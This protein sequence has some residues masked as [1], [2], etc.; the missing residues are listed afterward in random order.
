MEIL[1]DGYGRSMGFSTLKSNDKEGGAPREDVL[2]LR[3]CRLAMCSEVNPK[4]KFDTALVKKLVSGETVVAR[5]IRA[6]DSA[7]YEPKYKIFI[8]TNYAPIIPFDDKGSYRRIR[9][10]PFKNVIAEDKKDKTLKRT[11]KNEREARE[12]ILAWLIEGAVRSICRG[13]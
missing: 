6:K 11:F 8:G 1:K 13:A 7:E 3:S 10:N 4:T 9:V 12:R 2:R 5:G